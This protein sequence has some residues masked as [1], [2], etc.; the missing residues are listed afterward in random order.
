[1]KK[2]LIR[3]AGGESLL[4]KSG[5]VGQTI[6]LLH[7]FG[8]DS[9]IWKRV[10]PLLQ[11]YFRVVLVDLPGYGL[12]IGLWKGDMTVFT[13]F[14]NALFL[15]E[16]GAYVLGYS[17]GGNMLLRHV[18]KNGANQISGIIFLSIPVRIGALSYF[19]SLFLKAVSFSKNASEWLILLVTSLKIR[20]FLIAKTSLI[21]LNN[22][23]V[24]DFCVH[25]LV[26]FKNPA[27]LCESLSFVFKPLMKTG[28]LNVRAVGIFVGLDGFVKKEGVEGLFS[29]V[30]AHYKTFVIP[31]T[32]H[33][34]ALENPHKLA[35]TIIEA[36]QYIR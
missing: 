13:S 28:V 21:T 6:I 25:R 20:M 11:K 9:I 3:M 8:I 1:M 19:F 24:I 36:V 22:K 12:N 2:H 17:F 35:E 10:F 26:S 23:A 15:A 34:S 16:R 5:G 31:K 14:F 4:Y 30:F 32:H 29:A 33:L 18:L 27:F 7:G